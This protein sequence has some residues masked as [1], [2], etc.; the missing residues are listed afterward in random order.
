MAHDDR[1][2][3]IGTKSGLF[4]LE[5]GAAGEWS[6]RGPYLPDCDVGC[7]LATP[8][9]ALLVGTKADGIFRSDDRGASWRS[10]PLD[11]K[12]AELNAHYAAF[13]SPAVLNGTPESSVWALALAPQCGDTLYAGVLPAAIFRSRDGGESWEE[14]RGL[15]QM[16][17]SRE[18]WDLFQAPFLHSIVAGPQPERVAVGI[19]VG[20]VFQSEDGGESWR[21]A[22]A[23]HGGVDAAR[24]RGSTTSTSTSTSWWRRRR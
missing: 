19:S 7:A 15:R 18:F 23:G 11:R 14:L 24:R 20:G 4:E 2:L 10:L 3:L 21:V 22:T 6:Q 13:T 17:Q 8:S 5:A 12:H 9:G 16:P 1:C